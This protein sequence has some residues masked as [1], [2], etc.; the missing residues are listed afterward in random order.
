[1]CIR[2]RDYD[3]DHKLAKYQ[4]ICGTTCRELARKA[5]N[6]IRLKFYEVMAQP[7]LLFGSETWFPAKKTSV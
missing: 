4:S 6:E 5:K 1:M 3:V 7:V 2:D